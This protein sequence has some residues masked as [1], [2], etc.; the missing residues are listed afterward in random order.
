MQQ[1]VFTSDSYA[2]DWAKKH[3]DFDK[4]ELVSEAPWARV[5][6]L[7]GKSGG[8]YLRVLPP[9]LK[10]S[11]LTL[12]FLTRRFPQHMPELISNDPDL[13]LVLLK[14]H[15]G[16]TLDRDVTDTE[17]RDLL[18]TYASLQSEFSHQSDLAEYLPAVNLD[19]LVQ[20]LLQFLDP[21]A[22]REPVDGKVGSVY[23]VG[24]TRSRDYYEPLLRRAK[25]METQL[26]AAKQ[27]PATINHCDLRLK[28]AALTAGGTIVLTGW[29]DA[30]VGPA[31]LSL[32]S[33]F[34]G[35]A[36]PTALLEGSADEDFENVSRSRRMFEA[37]L[38]ALVEGGYASRE[39]LEHGL[40][41]AESPGKAFR[42]LS[43]PAQ[44]ASCSGMPTFHRTTGNTAAGYARYC[45]R[46]SVTSSIFAT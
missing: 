14:H 27:L 46:A 10:N 4:S 22:S 9:A 12:P 42:G 7:N 15:G 39:A 3:L 28:N 38:E 30:T 43:A 1:L 11:S 13:G 18:K 23:F 6:R 31:G 32:H 33:L 25:L 5:F 24:R 45:V 26:S 44:S 40:P 34:D 16:R 20:E 41:G 2:L 8:A 37:Y 36:T 19:S 29:D 17:L 21:T 35:C